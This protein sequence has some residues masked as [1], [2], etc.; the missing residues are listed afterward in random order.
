M[1]HQGIFRIG[2]AH[3]DIDTFEKSFLNEDDP[4]AGLHDDTHLNSVASILKRFFHR[5]PEPIFPK[6]Y[7]DQIMII[8]RTHPATGVNSIKDKMEQGCD[9]FKE[10]FVLAMREVVE[11]WSRPK[12]EVVS[13][14]FSLLA[15]LSKNSGVTQMDPYNI[16]ICF[17]PNLCPIPEG[18]DQM[19]YTNHVN[20]L[21][22][23]FIIFSKQIFGLEDVNS[24]QILP[25]HPTGNPKEKRLSPDLPDLLDFQ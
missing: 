12:K 21:I 22:K 25:S 1:N 3:N 2:G 24:P 7:L 8:A 9:R 10:G 16:A 23:N 18:Y 11:A 6:E 5:L 14:L 15:D 13:H 20:I 4:F 17:A 19:Q